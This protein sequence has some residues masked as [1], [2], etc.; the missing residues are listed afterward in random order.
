MDPWPTTSDCL[1][2]ATPS[3]ALR[4]RSMQWLIAVGWLVVGLATVL[5]TP[6]NAAPVEGFTEPYRQ[7]EVASAAEVGLVTEFAVK[8]GDRVQPGQLLA[9]LDTELLVATLKVA[10]RRATSQGHLKAAVA[11]LELRRTRI[12]KLRELRQKGHA[13]EAEVERAEADLA[14]AEANLMNAQ[15]EKELYELECERIESQITRRR[16]VSPI[17]GVVTEVHREVGES[18]ALNDP[19]LLTL[20]QLSPLRAKFS[21]TM[22]QARSL[23]AGQKTSLNLPEAEAM[24]ESQIEVISPILDARSGT[25]QV[26]L[27]MDNSRGDLRSGMRCVWEVPD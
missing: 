12:G 11:E 6:C 8:E 16:I 14:V 4:V 13:S 20:V 17:A 9:S 18:V 10:Q 2:H 3:H 23:V 15:E 5:A 7:V 25:V 26:T 1:M 21:L 19:K 27:V 24:V 22:S